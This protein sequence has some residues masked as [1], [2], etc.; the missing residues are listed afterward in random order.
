MSTATA[1]PK[2]DRRRQQIERASLEWRS[3]LIDVSGNNRL[4]F[5]KPTAATL[6]L[7]DANSA[8]LAELLA[9][10]TVHLTKL[11]DDPVRVALAQRAIK[12]LAGKQREAEEEYGVSVAFCAF[13]IATWSRNPDDLISR[14]EVISA[15]NPATGEVAALEISEDPQGRRSA[16]GP[17]PPSAPVMLRAVELTHRSGTVDSWELTLTGDAQLNPV[18]L[19]VLG[20]QGARVD[21]EASLEAGD[22]TRGEF[23][24]IYDHLRKA[25]AEV[26]GFSIDE[27]MMLGAFSYLKQPMVADCEDIEALLTSDLV[28][29][30]AGDEDS[31]EGIRSIADEISDFDPDYKPVDSEFLVLD[32]DASQSFVV[33]AA[34]AG[35]NLVVQGPPGTGKSQTIANVIAALVAEGKKVLFVAQ[36]RAAITAVLDRLENVGLGE[37]TLDL[38]AAGSS[39]R[40]VAEELGK[41]LDRQASVGA[42]IT[43]SLHKFLTAARDRLVS[44]R[45]AL[46]TRKVAWG[47][48]VSDLFALSR[49]IPESITSSLR[50][51]SETLQKWSSNDLASLAADF[52]EI[53]SKGGFDPERLTRVGWSPVALISTEDVATANQS[54]VAVS[55]EL[56]PMAMESLE[57]L[58]AELGIAMPLEP[59]SVGRLLLNLAE[60]AQLSD[61]IPGAFDSSVSSDILEHLLIAT[62]KTYRKTSPIK[63][64]W[65]ARRK[66]RRVAHAACSGDPAQAADVTTHKLLLRGKA[67]RES[68]VEEG[69]NGQVRSVST[70]PAAQ[71]AIAALIRRLASL[72]PY[73]QN[74]A[75]DE[76]SLDR[77][78][79]ILQA[80]A[81]DQTRAQF[82]RLHEI[83]EVLAAAGL[84]QLISGARRSAAGGDP[85]VGRDADSAAQTLRYIAVHSA[86]EQAL[87]SDPAL[88]G[89]TG[90]DLHS[91]AET[92]RRSDDEHLQ[93]NA[94]RVRRAAAVRLTEELNKHSDQYLLLKREVTK[95][96][97]FRPVRRLFSEAP[98]VMTAV[99]PCWAMSPLQVSRLL[100]ASSCFDVVIFDEASQVKPADAIPALIRAPQ[101]IVAGDSRQLPPTEFFTKVLEDQAD[102]VTSNRSTARAEEDALAAEASEEDV[103]LDSVEE[104]TASERPAGESYTRDAESI[105]FAFDRILV[106]QSRRLL[107]HY[108]SRDERLIAVSNAYVYDWSLTTFP[109]AD[110]ADCI[111]HEVVAPSPGIKGGSNSP[112]DEVSRVAELVVDHALHHPDET[113]GVITFGVPHMRRIQAALDAIFTQDPEIEQ[114]LNSNDREPFFIKNIER[115]QGDERDSIILTFGYGEG[116]DGR[117]RLFWGPLLQP[118]GERR[119]NVAISRAR[120]RMTLVTSFAGDD[121][122][123]DAHHSVG[124]KLMYRFVRFMASGGTE[125]AGDVRRNVSLNAFEIDIRDRLTEAGLDLVPQLGAGNYRLDFAARHPGHPGRYVLAI[126]ADG[127]SYHSGHIAR[128]RDRLRQRL[129]EARGWIFY[130]IWSTD[131]FNDATTEIQKVMASFESALAKSKDTFLHDDHDAPED[132]A[133]SEVPELSPTWSIAEANRTVPK[134]PIIPGMSIDFY[135]RALLV[136]LVKHIRSDGILRPQPDEMLEVMRELGFQRRGPKIVA[137]ITAAQKTVD[138][139]LR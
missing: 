3:A 67:S 87:I 106:G 90:S 60:A 112:D 11:F 42:P 6:D 123:E 108:R 121:V 44:H 49:S 77:L 98:E 4:L 83:E 43:T 68:W 92:F 9:G 39:R 79:G 53:A 31:V 57:L 23:A 118:G 96:R 76:A 86:I 115:V 66:A 16:K 51:P 75:L 126:E 18:L 131:W 33:N 72:A 27:R 135:S 125:L 26:V 32:A 24:P 13:G 127:A 139:S 22:D 19:H 134:P 61:L 114:I 109:A 110:G 97:N 133:E 95:K 136:K 82:P 128:E 105:L 132:S 103:N 120:A 48:T 59:G 88:A 137:E 2:S 25:C 80:L 119:L 107:W 40:Y 85:L 84:G 34:L 113:L 38:F 30:L 111:R 8:A 62:D 64:S 50:L 70:F 14:A 56:L 55:N 20:S 52:G 101:A 89:I 36:K 78:P 47:I 99:K 74:L 117:L 5:F 46:H 65:G 71:Q 37:I 94:A 58:A 93:A 63:L 122:A 100:P 7:A 81:S 15:A 130:R 91:A 129:L 138:R 73:V 45:N 102:D 69:R 41:V 28:A 29:A 12:G 35:R 54:L 104:A 21:E 17:T 116:I 124:Y 1:N 10:T